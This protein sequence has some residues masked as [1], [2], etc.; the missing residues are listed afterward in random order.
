LQYFFFPGFPF[1]FSLHQP[2]SICV[3]FLNLH[4]PWCVLFACYFFIYS[5]SLRI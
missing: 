3:L 4:I 2:L 5:S 1:A